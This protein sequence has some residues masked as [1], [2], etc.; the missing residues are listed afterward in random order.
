[1]YYTI[2]L[3]ETKQ[4]TKQ[5]AIS[6]V[7]RGL[8]LLCTATGLGADFMPRMDTGTDQD[9]NMANMVGVHVSYSCLSSVPLTFICP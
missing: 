1:M 8:L 6:S 3:S 9:L 2:M 7:L 5:C 4:D